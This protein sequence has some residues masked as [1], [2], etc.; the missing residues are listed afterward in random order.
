MHKLEDKRFPSK[1]LASRFYSQC[2]RKRLIH[3]SAFVD[4]LLAISWIL[5]MLLANSVQ[6]GSNSKQ[7]QQNNSQQQQQ[8]HSCNYL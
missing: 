4:L 1:P 5:N 6:Q 2:K 7:Q 8:F 3:N